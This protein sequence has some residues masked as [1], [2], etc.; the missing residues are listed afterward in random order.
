M[1]KGRRV[2]LPYGQFVTDVTRD[3]L[4]EVSCFQPAHG[5][6]PNSSQQAF[7]LPRATTLRHASG[8]SGVSWRVQKK[9][10]TMIQEELPQQAHSHYRSAGEDQSSVTVRPPSVASWRDSTSGETTQGWETTEAQ[11][12]MV[13]SCVLH[14]DSTLHHHPRQGARLRNALSRSA[15]APSETD[16]F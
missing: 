16:C 3:C 1:A 14:E 2:V 9:N 5:D 13:T 6:F 15:S 11:P 8:W 4:H 7:C 10:S 12:D